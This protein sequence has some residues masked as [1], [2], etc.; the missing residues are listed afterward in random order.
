M[1]V[2]KRG[3]SIIPSVPLVLNHSRARVE[4]NGK[5][6]DSSKIWSPLYVA[7]FSRPFPAT[8]ARNQAP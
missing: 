3:D 7:N 6:N 8:K 5:V 4:T 2:A 1:N